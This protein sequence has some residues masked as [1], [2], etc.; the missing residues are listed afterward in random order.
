MTPR[1]LQ[2]SLHLVATTTIREAAAAL[3]LSPK[4]VEYHLHHVYLRLGG[5]TRARLAQRMHPT[6]VVPSAV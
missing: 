4:T 3:F 2:I 1:E 5:G 6:T